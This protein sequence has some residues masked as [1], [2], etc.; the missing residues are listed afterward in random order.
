MYPAT[1]PLMATQQIDV[2]AGREHSKVQNSKRTWVKGAYAPKGVDIK[3]C[4]VTTQ[5][6][7]KQAFTEQNVMHAVHDSHVLQASALR[8]SYA[9]G[10]LVLG[11]IAYFSIPLPTFLSPLYLPSLYGTSIVTFLSH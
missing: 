6:L 5:N 7:L 11:R 9:C 10:L 4:A 2:P 3:Y 8:L 1:D